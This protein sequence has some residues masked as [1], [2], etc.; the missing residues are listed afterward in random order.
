MDGADIANIPFVALPSTMPGRTVSREE[1]K[2]GYWRSSR[3]FC[4]PAWE[5]RREA[6]SSYFQ[7]I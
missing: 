5:I 4:R 7:A 6:T 3:Q 1:C 2:S